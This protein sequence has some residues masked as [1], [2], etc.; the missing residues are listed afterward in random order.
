MATLKINGGNKLSGTVRIGGSKNAVLPIICATIL[1]EKECV[2]KNVP[3]ILDV[4]N[5]IEI[6]EGI[7]SKIQYQDRTITIDNSGVN[8][9][10]PDKA[11]V[12]KLRGS[13]LLLGPLLARFGE[14]EIPYPGGD[15]IGKRPID[16]HLVAMQ[17]LGATVTE[18]DFVH[19]KAEKLKS[20][21]IILNEMSVTATE[22][23]IMAA[24]KADGTVSIHLAAAEPHVQD[25]CHF[26]NAM[27]AKIAGIGTH[28][29]IIEGVKELH[30]A[31][32]EIIFDDV[33]ATSFINLAAATRSDVLITQVK[34]EYMYGALIQFQLMGVNFKIEEETIHVM[35]PL[36]PYKAAKIKTSIYPG[37]LSDYVPP[38]AVLA[39]QAEGVS[40]VHEWMYEGRLG[41]IHELTK[42]GAKTRI[43]DQHRAEI[44]GPSHLHGTNVS[45]LDVRSGMVLVIA[46][47]V[48]EGTS[49]LHDIE[50]IDRGYE[51]LDV[52]LKRLGADI[53]RVED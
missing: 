14:V 15:L 46:A 38:F 10:K 13:I 18:G 27:G 30:G 41:Y 1:T 32:H 16:T 31:E 45:S 12:K 8:S 20:A 42:M 26:L 28:N 25:L 39:T 53:E 5:L 49:T 51:N 21:K 36:G 24:V 11:L 43:L 52:I 2:L 3:D 4:K 6:L 34:P 47:L 40:L 29:L 19:V 17:E 37:L 35:P 7:G 44:Q 48:A 9:F 50:H 22:N 23:A 33:V